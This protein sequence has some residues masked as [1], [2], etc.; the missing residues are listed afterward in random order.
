MSGRSERGRSV[1][2]T[3]GLKRRFGPIVAVDRLEL[4]VERQSVYGFLGPNGAGKTTT[5][6]MLLGLIQPTDDQVHIFNKPLSQDIGPILRKIG[7]LVEPPALYPHQIG[8]ENL[9]MTR[10]LIGGHREQIQ[11]VFSIVDMVQDAA[12]LVRGYS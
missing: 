2:Q 10:R 4:R 8:Y 3:S 11:R 1:I 6:R 9:E 5:I 12:R 7:A